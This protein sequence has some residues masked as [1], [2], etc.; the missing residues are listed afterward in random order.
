MAFLFYENFGGDVLTDAVS[1]V[2]GVL[3]AFVLLILAPM[4]ITRMRDDMATRRLVL[5]EVTMFRLC[6]ISA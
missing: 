5:N 6:G 3:L 2:I 4:T 1:K